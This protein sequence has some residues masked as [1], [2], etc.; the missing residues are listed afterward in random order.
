MPARNMDEFSNQYFEAAWFHWIKFCIRFAGNQ[1][2]IYTSKIDMY[3]LDLRAIKPQ[4][5]TVYIC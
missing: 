5:R 2:K 1:N 3:N 4:I